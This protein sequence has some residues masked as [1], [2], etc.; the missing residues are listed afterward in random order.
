MSSIETNLSVDPYNDDYDPTKDFY[1]N[2]FRPEMAVQAR[3]LTQSQTILQNQI[4]RFADNIITEG[5][6]VDGCNFNYDSSVG[7][8]KLRDL[9]L[10]LQT[11]DVND[12]VGLK[13]VDAATGLFAFVVDVADGYET[14]NPDMKTI[15]VKYGNTGSSEKKVFAADDTLTFYDGDT[16]ITELA[17]KVVPATL[18][19][20]PTNPIGNSYQFSVSAGYIYQK[21]YFLR[22]ADGISVI[23]SKYDNVP[24]NKIVGFITEE[25]IV[26]EYSDTSLYDNAGGSPNENAPGAHRLKLVPTLEVYDADDPPSV[27]FFTLAEWENGLVVKESRN[28]QYSGLGQELARRTAEESGDYVVDPFIFTTSNIDGN[29]SH[30]NINSTQGIAYVDGY[31][32]EKTNN[33]STPIRKGTDTARVTAQTLVSNYGNYILV[34]DLVGTFESQKMVTISLRDTA[35]N[36]IS[37]GGLA[38]TAPGNEI[39]TATLLS[40]LND[41]GVPGTATAQYRLYITNIVMASGKNFTDVRAVNITGGVADLVLENSIAVLK[42]S[43]FP[44]LVYSFGQGAIKTLRQG[45]NNTNQFIFRTVNSSSKI[46]TTGSMGA[47]VL[48]GNQQYTY[49]TGT[50]NETLESRV[51]VIPTTAANVS[52]AKS[53]TVTVNASSNIV[54]G[55]STAFVTEFQI[56][57]FLWCNNQARQISS[58]SN[59]TYLNTISNFSSTFT[60][61]AYAKHYPAGVPIPFT[62]RQ[63]I[64]TCSNTTSLALTLKAS[65]GATE[66][67]SANLN[68]NVFY[69]VQKNGAVQLGKE[70][71]EDRYV[72]ID[73]SNNAANT[74]GPWC[75]GL[76]DVFAISKVYKSGGYT[77]SDTYD[78]TNQFVLDPGQKDAIYGLSY[79]R[80]KPGTTLSLTSGD[81]LLVKVDVFKPT[82]G[83]GYGFF[84]IDSYPIDDANTA[85]TTAITTQEIPYF[86]S[87]TTGAVYSLRDS[88]D[89]RPVPSNTAVYSNTESAASINP[90]TTLVFS[91]TENYVVSPNQ[92]FASSLEY[93]LGRVDRLVL[94]TYGNFTVI[95]GNPRPNPTAPPEITEAMSVA[96][97]DVKPYPSLSM[98][99]AMTY[100]R[101]SSAVTLNSTQTKRFTMKDI[102]DLENRV[103]NV[104]YY[105]ALNLLEKKT[106]ELSI[107]DQSG[108]ER[109]KNGIFVDDFVDTSSLA[110][111]DAEFSAEVDVRR[112]VIGP[113]QDTQI[114]ELEYNGGNNIHSSGE[115]VTLDYEDITMIR[116]SFASSSRPC[117]PTSSWDY[118]PPTVDISP[119]YDP[120]YEEEAP[121]YIQGAPLSGGNYELNGEMVYYL[122][123]PVYNDNGVNTGITYV[124]TDE[125]TASSVRQT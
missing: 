22:V 60:T 77:E 7:Y 30:L 33:L 53:G 38:T 49:G 81:K 106:T 70:V 40:V 118:S 50:L 84:S 125:T 91:N 76:P 92:P 57:D 109:F 121:G 115:V 19:G 96:T 102:S 86:T 2:L 66:T 64:I 62:N 13:A 43:A 122:I 55:S 36:S 27:T 46:D 123:V 39:G 111:G 87:P 112:S 119:S 97:I 80:R 103:D 9:R 90:G 63:S 45:S 68:V 113:K 116:Q 32:V 15:F 3:E 37:G 44:A 89:F 20:N 18:D 52:L 75:L 5:S 110:T 10:D 4:S 94:D 100:G 25:S 73:C 117:A 6:I 98:Q 67:L 59:N 56:G 72:K 65:N 1:K 58:I 17:T 14:Q 120:G 8:A 101:P 21:G 23:V 83:S 93:Y 54:V 74:V 16:E 28:T 104:E 42:E 26:T 105:T 35:A 29:T 48:S 41:S 11:L 61:N 34:D 71:Q 47:I 51:I 31:R 107:K 108:L 88:L 99:D 12:L 78:V 69:D 114:I 85:N 124:L 95:E 24:D 79:L 82:V